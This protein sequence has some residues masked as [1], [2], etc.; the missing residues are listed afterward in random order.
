M[1]PTNEALERQVEY[2]LGSKTCTAHCGVCGKTKSQ[3]KRFFLALSTAI[4]K[5]RM[6]FNFCET[7]GKWVC[8][9]CFLIDDGN[10][11]SIGICASCAKEQSIK[12]LTSDELVEAWPKIQCRIQRRNAVVKRAAE[13][14]K[15]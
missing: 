13:K 10:G 7:C 3:K 12:G 9:D 1:R 4:G 8:E 11:N 2:D 15:Q 14:Q 6:Q 5:L